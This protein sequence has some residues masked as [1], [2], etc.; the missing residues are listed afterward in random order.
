MRI[1]ILLL[2]LAVPLQ[3]ETWVVMAKPG[4][5]V[6]GTFT[7]EKGDEINIDIDTR[8][9]CVKAFEITSDIPVDLEQVITVEKVKGQV[10][11][12]CSK[13]KIK[14]GFKQAKYSHELK[15]RDFK[16]RAVK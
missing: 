3:A 15:P 14:A 4:M 6:I 2:F 13:E 7:A 8:D 5:E 10:K 16:L 1:L 11:I 9:L 12:G